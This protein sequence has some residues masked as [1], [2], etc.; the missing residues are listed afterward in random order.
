MIVVVVVVVGV[1]VEVGGL[2]GGARQN[3]QRRIEQ[4][5][6]IPWS[7]FFELCKREEGEGEVMRRGHS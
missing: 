7:H 2:V 3:K 5:N 6:P 4:S 1:W